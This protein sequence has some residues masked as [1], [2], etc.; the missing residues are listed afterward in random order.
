M[1]V[2]YCQKG[3]LRD[4]MRENREGFTDLTSD[5]YLNHVGGA[6]TEAPGKGISTIELI[7]WSSE[8]AKGMEFLASKN[9]RL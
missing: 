8:V 3:N 1:A 7:R 9:V 5:E 4:F 6:T 2:E